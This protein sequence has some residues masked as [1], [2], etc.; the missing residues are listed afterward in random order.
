MQ[1][2]RLRHEREK[3]HYAFQS[4]AASLRWNRFDVALAEQELEAARRKT[5]AAGMMYFAPET[6]GPMSP[7]PQKEK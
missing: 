7:L 5:Q 4:Q 3:M 6:L 2:T 1:L